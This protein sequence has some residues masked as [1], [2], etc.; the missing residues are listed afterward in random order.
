MT[1]VI[2]GLDERTKRSLRA[3]AVRRG[4]R[5]ADAVKEAFQVWRSYDHDAQSPSERDV[6][7]AAYNALRQE[8]GKYKGKTVVIAAGKFLGVYENPRSA[9]AELK[10]KAPEARHAIITVIGKDR[11]E[12]LDWSGGSLNL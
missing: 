1:L 9:A 8:L 3:E 10:S 2:R 5:L 4:L 6:N 12:E 7:N 11:R